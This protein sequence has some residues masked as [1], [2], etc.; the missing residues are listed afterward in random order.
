MCQHKE[1]IINI[2]VYLHSPLEGH[3]CDPGKATSCATHMQYQS[4]EEPHDEDA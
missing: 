3:G 2:I 4:H 1:L